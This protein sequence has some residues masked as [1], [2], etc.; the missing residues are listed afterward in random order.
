[1]CITYDYFFYFNKRVHTRIPLVRARNKK[2]HCVILTFRS[3]LTICLQKWS[4]EKRINISM[5]VLLL[6]FSWPRGNGYG[7]RKNMVTIIITL[8]TFCSP[9]YIHRVSSMTTVASCTQFAKTQN[10]GRV[11]PSIYDAFAKHIQ[12]IC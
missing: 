1:M 9:L 2:H 7:A 5:N 12:R 4:L 10:I 11:Y 3:T 6:P 8:S